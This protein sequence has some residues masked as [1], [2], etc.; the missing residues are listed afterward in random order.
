MADLVRFVEQ[1]WIQS[2][3]AAR[4]HSTAIHEALCRYPAQGLPNQDFQNVG[5]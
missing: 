4:R 2:F 5:E 1:G 3:V